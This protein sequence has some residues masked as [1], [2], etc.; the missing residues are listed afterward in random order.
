MYFVERFR[1][2]KDRGVYVMYLLL[3]VL[4]VQVQSW[5]G[6][7]ANLNRSNEF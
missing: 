3:K 5:D 6:T 1:R 2:S 4:S 7:Y